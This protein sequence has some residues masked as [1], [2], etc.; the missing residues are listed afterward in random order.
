MVLTA[1]GLAIASAIVAGLLPT[2]RAC[3]VAPAV[4]LTSH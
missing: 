4:Q 1:I 2:W 3:Q